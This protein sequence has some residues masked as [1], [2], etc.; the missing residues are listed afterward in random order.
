MN[1]LTRLADV[2]LPPDPSWWPYGLVLVVVTV[3]AV[4]WGG[5]WWGRRQARPR[6]AGAGQINATAVERLHAARAAWR[7]GQIDARTAAYRV[8][9]IL[10][11]AG[12]AASEHE[13]VGKLL[14]ARYSA[15]PIILSE[16]VFE[17]VEHR[18]VQR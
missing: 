15:A 18:L 2:D 12:V 13:E 11:L 5:Q 3:A 7:A 16:R 8:A 9:A 10:R 1:E 6:S 17:I 4:W 14:R